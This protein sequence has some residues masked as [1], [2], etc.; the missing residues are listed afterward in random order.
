MTTCQLAI[1]CDLRPETPQTVL[2]RW[3]SHAGSAGAQR[4]FGG[5]SLNVHCDVADDELDAC[6]D[7]LETLAPYSTTDGF[8]GYLRVPWDISP[9]LIYFR[10]GRVSLF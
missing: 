6:F 5:A 2:D 8:V 4:W 7:L 10:D 9:G 1:A 3:S